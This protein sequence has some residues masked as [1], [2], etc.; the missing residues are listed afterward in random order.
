MKQEK[1]FKPTVP[2]GQISPLMNRNRKN[3]KKGP[4]VG[5]TIV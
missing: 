2:Q 3:E 1:L 4:M 5:K